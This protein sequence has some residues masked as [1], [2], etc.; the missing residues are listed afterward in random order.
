[1]DERD[2]SCPRELDRVLAGRRLERGVPGCLQ[3]VAEELHVH[4]VVLDDQ[5]RRTGHAH[6]SAG[7]VKENRLPL[8]S[9]LSTQI[10]PPW[11][12]ISRVESASPRPVPSLCS[13]PASVCWNSSKMRC[14]SSDA[15]PAPVSLTDTQ[16]SPPT[17]SA[18]TATL[19]PGGVNLT[20]FD[21]RLNTT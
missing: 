1:Q 10:R 8:P 17:R 6:A 20:A 18:A 2:A 21:S 15:I 3:H 7:S 11:R 9:A 19:P 12:S 4:V 5:N 14:W 16:T 13:A